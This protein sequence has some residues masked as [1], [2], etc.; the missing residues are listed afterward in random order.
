MK[1]EIKIDS[2]LHLFTGDT[3]YNRDKIGKPVFDNGNVV[4]TNGRMLLIAPEKYIESGK[5]E[6]ITDKFPAY[7]AIIPAHDKDVVLFETDGNFICDEVNLL[8]RKEEYVEC[9]RCEGEGTLFTT[10]HNS[11]TCDE[12]E[13]SGNGEYLGNN[14]LTPT[15]E[16]ES[17]DRRFLIKVKDSYFNPNYMQNISRIA[18]GLNKPMKWVM[19]QALSHCIIYIDDIM[20]IIMPYKWDEIKSSYSGDCQIIEIP[21]L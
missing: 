14:V 6:N 17:G 21:T 3:E 12:C 10:N 5:Y 1:N 2:I 13:G 4:A 20:I 18:K 19:C 9:E 8:E 16:D 11:V 15:L 7:K